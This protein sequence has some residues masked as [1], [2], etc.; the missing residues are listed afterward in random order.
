MTTI[1]NTPST[2]GVAPVLSGRIA[3]PAACTGQRQ[4]L[5]HQTQQA[6]APR[7]PLAA[8]AVNAAPV[9]RSARSES[10]PR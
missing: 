2:A 9:E 8:S 1:G 5:P 7:G 4:A 6:R 3:N 10:G